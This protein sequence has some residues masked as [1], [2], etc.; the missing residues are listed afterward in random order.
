M[1]WSFV[2]PVFNLD[3]CGWF[4][5]WWQSYQKLSML[6]HTSTLKQWNVCTQVHT[7]LQIQAAGWWQS[8]KRRNKERLFCFACLVQDSHVF[9]EW[10]GA[11]DTV[12]S[13]TRNGGV[14]HG[15]RALLGVNFLPSSSWQLKSVTWLWYWFLIL[16]LSARHW[17]CFL[18]SSLILLVMSNFIFLF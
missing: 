8:G 9:K 10:E 5:V 15:A 6:F 17:L 18:V 11:A 14:T 12:L 7:V 3:A 1:R 13:I 16:L 2:F 4:G